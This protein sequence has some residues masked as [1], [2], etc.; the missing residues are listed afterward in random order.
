LIRV[1]IEVDGGTGGSAIV[2]QAES[3]R[4]ALSIAEDLF[5]GGNNRVV[6]PI[7]PESFFA[8]LGVSGAVE[9]SPLEK[10]A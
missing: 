5:P 3:I 8:A 7:E 6:F 10:T 1:N 9:A 2:V 4:H